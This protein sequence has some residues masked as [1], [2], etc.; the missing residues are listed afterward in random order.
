MSSSIAT[1][2]DDTKLFKEVNSLDDTTA[3]Q[4]DLSNFEISSSNAG[5]QLNTSKCKAFHATRRHKIIEQPYSVENQTLETS[6]H[7]R[8]LGVWISNNLL[9]LT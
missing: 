4:D 3:L 1:Y 5:L 2:A 7:E 6:K 8:D 9:N